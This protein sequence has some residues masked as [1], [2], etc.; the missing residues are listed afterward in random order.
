MKLRVALLLALACTACKDEGVERYSLALSKYQECVDQ[1]VSPNDPRF[2]EVLKLLDAVPA[3]SSAHVRAEALR[4]SLQSA[5]AP[6]L[7]TPLAIQGGANLSAEVAA[8]L[9][10]C[11]L[12]AEQLGTTAE[13]DRPAKLRA[14]DACRAAAEKLDAEHVHDGGP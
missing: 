2:V 7:R 9:A 4:Q 10:Q 5:Q 14:L 11:R 1:G 8:Q 12:L 3:S 6:R 13:A